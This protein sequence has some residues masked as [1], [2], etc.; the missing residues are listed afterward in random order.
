MGREGRSYV[1]G[2]VEIK[3]ESV[4]GLDDIKLTA[5]FGRECGL[6]IATSCSGQERHVLLH[7][8][9]KTKQVVHDLAV[10]IQLTALKRTREN[11][12]Q[13]HRSVSRARKE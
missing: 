12:S 1:Q 9:R 2:Q 8:E 4:L 10:I 13:T 11:S 7:G 5:T 6:L 3:A